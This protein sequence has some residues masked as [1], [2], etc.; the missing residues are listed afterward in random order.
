M[1]IWNLLWEYG[2]VFTVLVCHS[3]KNLATLHGDVYSR[4]HFRIRLLWPF[5]TFRREL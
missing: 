1:D 3:K 2:A 5:M 4:L